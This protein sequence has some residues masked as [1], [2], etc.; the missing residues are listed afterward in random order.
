MIAKVQELNV[1]MGKF[2]N[3]LCFILP[4]MFIGLVAMTTI[5]LHP[6]FVGRGGERRQMMSSFECP[7]G[8]PRTSKEGKLIWP[9]NEG[10]TR[11]CGEAD[12][13]HAE[14][15]NE[16]NN[17]G[18]FDHLVDMCCGSN[19]QCKWKRACE[20]HEA[21]DPKGYKCC[22]FYCCGHSSGGNSMWDMKG[23]HQISPEW[24][25]SK[26]SL[27]ECPMMSPRDRIFHLSAGSWELSG[28]NKTNGAMVRVE[29]WFNETLTLDAYVEGT[30]DLGC[31]CSLR[32]RFSKVLSILWKNA[33]GG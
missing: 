24:A 27:E 2:R 9:M 13:Y 21:K 11:V 17:K 5:Q 1:V 32:L 30:M 22:A 29:P 12:K 8:M 19:N 20:H 3:P 18:C 33:C 4:P 15:C 10:D 26:E 28:E 7:R 25:G 31:R 16:A 23:P 6:I 14:Y